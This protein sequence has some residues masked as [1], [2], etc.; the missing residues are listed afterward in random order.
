MRTS[1]RVVVALWIVAGLLLV[2]VVAGAAKGN[3]TPKQTH[4]CTH[5]VSSIGPVELMNGKVVGGSTTP[6]TEACLR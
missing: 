2:L 1:R 5:G 6:H 4:A 3:G